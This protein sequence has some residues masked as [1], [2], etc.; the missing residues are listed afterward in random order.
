[1]INSP[2]SIES[3]VPY[4]IEQWIVPS[5]QPTTSA[6]V[7]D[8]AVG[9]AHTCFIYANHEAKCVG[10]NNKGQLKNT[11]SR[12]TDATFGSKI[13][14]FAS[15]DQPVQVVAGVARTCFRYRDTNSFHV[16]TLECLGEKGTNFASA[17][18]FVSFTGAYANEF[19][20]DI[21]MGN[22]AGSTED[23]L[24]AILVFDVASTPNY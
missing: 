3:Q 11:G 8:M 10:L 14:T 22:M 24:C 1:M 6:H 16:Y 4:L 5:P 15:T 7:L 9:S 23:F 20:V 17:A 2:G 19:P 13:S 18:F 12:I 21:A